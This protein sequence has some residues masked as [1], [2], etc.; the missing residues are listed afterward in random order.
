MFEKALEVIFAITTAIWLSSSLILS[1]RS[2]A[3]VKKNLSSISE[4]MFGNPHYFKK[5]DLTNF[6]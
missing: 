5:L 2:Y 6:F 1:F 3:Y 4:L